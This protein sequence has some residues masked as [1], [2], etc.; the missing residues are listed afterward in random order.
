MNCKVIVN[1]DSGN[2]GRLDIDALLNMLGCA[3]D[4]VQ[5]VNSDCDWTA[6]NCDTVVVCGGD[7][8]LHCALEKCA[9]KQIVYAPCGTLNELSKTNGAIKS[10]GKVNDM[11]F[12]YVCAT[13]SFT[14][15]GYSAN[16]NHKKRFKALAYLPQVLTCYKSHVI[17]AKLNVD[18]KKYEDD[19]TLLMVL[20]SNRCFGFNFNKS[21]NNRNGLYLVAVRSFGENSFINKV[22]MFAPF[23]RVFFCG[24]NAP[25][26]KENWQVVPFENLSVTINSPQ[27]FCLD[28]E[29]RI[30][31]GELH[32]CEQTL[33]KQIEIIKTPYR[34]RLGKF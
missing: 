10:I 5:Y 9:D 13:G 1:T 21:Y 22:K 31:Q 26:V 30:L 17:H 3:H 18:G 29:K 23:F 2:Y 19:Y 25:A 8:T 24:V 33:N 11:P 15:I 16:N 7:G 27:D 28:G 14:E 4:D 12:S 32:F 20:K 6:E 34:S